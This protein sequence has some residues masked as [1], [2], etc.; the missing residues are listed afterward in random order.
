MDHFLVPGDEYEALEETAENL[1][2]TGTLTAIEDINTRR[3]GGRSPPL[4]V[5]AVAVGDR[6]VGAGGRTVNSET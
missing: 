3:E 5:F 6:I 1:S 2:D 4:Y